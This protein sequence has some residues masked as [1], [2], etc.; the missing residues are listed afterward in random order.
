MPGLNTFETAEMCSH[1]MRT[2]IAEEP[3]AVSCHQKNGGL[4]IMVRSYVMSHTRS[5]LF[6]AGDRPLMRVPKLTVCV[7]WWVLWVVETG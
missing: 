1:I 3:V 6:V 4:N 2:T 7:L 5:R